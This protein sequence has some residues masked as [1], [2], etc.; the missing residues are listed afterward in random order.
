MMIQR[1]KSMKALRL[2]EKGNKSKRKAVEEKEESGMKTALNAFEKSG[3]GRRSRGE[4][5]EVKEVKEV[6]EEEE[7]EQTQSKHPTLLNPNHN[8]H[9]PPPNTI[10]LTHHHLNKQNQTRWSVG[11]VRRRDMEYG[12][13]LRTETVSKNKNEE[14]T[15]KKIRKRRE[16]ERQQ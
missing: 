14:S 8:H 5:K 6:E 12:I 2:N 1:W 13:T 11:I 10:Q 4:V 16:G 3:R 15:V 7:L 9:Q